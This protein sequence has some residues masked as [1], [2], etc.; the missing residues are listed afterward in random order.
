MTVL[1]RQ[2]QSVADE[3][4]GRGLPAPADAMR[5]ARFR[6][7]APWSWCLRC[8][9]GLSS[10]AGDG[11]H[12][13]RGPDDPDCVVRLGAHEGALRRWVV[14]MKHAGWEA[15]AEPLGAALAAQLAACAAIAPGEVDVVV[16]PVPTPW[17]RARSRGIAHAEAVACALARAA[18]L[19]CVRALR[20]RHAGSQ[21]R[22]HGRDSRRARGGRFAARMPIAR[23]SRSVA[24]LHVVLVDDVRTTGATLREASRVLRGIGAARITAAVLGVRERFR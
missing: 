14:D 4:L 22:A 2:L 10:G 18:S 5:R 8:G 17:L 20:Q 12:C 15:M 21:V 9:E 16:G 7:D 3:L 24:G 6:P 23:A 1:L 11:P 19:R 13:V